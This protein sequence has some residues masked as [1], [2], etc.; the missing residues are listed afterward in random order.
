M[1]KM[2]KDADLTWEIGTGTLSSPTVLGSTNPGAITGASN[3]AL[4]E[5]DVSSWI[6]TLA[7]ANDLKLKINNNNTKGKKTYQDYIYAVIE[8]N[9]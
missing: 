3:E 5:W 4:V 6:D 9:P 2:I 8:Y 7:E 1:R